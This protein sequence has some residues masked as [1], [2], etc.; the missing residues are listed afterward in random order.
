MASPLQQ[1]ITWLDQAGFYEVVV[2][3]AFIF[4]IT[5]GFLHA[6][7]VF[8]VA[9]NGKPKRSINAGVALAFSLFFIIAKTL[10][11]GLNLF[12][13]NLVMVVIVLL[14][15]ALVFGF[16][17]IPF[18]SSWVRWFSLFLF[19]GLVV[20]TFNLF[21]LVVELVDYLT[22]PFAFIVYIILFIVLS[23]LKVYQ[24]GKKEPEEKREIPREEVG[25]FAS[26]VPKKI[27]E[28]GEE[29][30]KKQGFRLRP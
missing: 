18:K 28:I 29:D 1:V 25:E 23:T 27:G 3:F 30:L 24:K 10:V 12:L 6:T 13:G 15:V 2:P 14:G 4:A 5:Y 21:S 26:K 9:K 7:K 16:L 22:T 8:G 19:L 20:A 17:K 11:A